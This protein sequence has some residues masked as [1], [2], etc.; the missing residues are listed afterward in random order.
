MRRPAPPTSASST[1]A[2]T[3]SA[4]RSASRAGRTSC[5]SSTL[6]E[7][8]P[9]TAGGNIVQFRVPTQLERAGDFSQSR[10][11]NGNLINAIY[12]APP[13]CR[14][15]SAS[16]AAPRRPA[17]RTAESSARSRRTGCTGSGRTFSTSGRSRRTSRRPLAGATTTRP[18]RR[19]ST[20]SRRSPHSGWTIRPRRNCGSAARASSRSATPRSSRDRFRASTTRG[21]RCRTSTRGR[22]RRTTGSAPT[23]FFEGTYGFSQNQLGAPGVTPYYNKNNLG[24]GSIP[25][26]YPDSGKFD[27]SYYEVGDPEQVRRAILRRRRVPTAADLGLGHQ[28]HGPTLP[29]LGYPSFLNLNR[30]QSVLGSLTKVAGPS[31][32]ES[33][34]QHPAQLQGGE[35]EH[36]PGAVDPG[37]HQFREGHQQPARH[38]LRLRQCGAR[39]LQHLRAAEHPGRRHLPAQHVRGLR[40]GQLEGEQPG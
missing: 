21:T 2:G 33:R 1:T 16:R 6:D 10:D 12:D 11:N 39:H 22:R 15:V 13:G 9:R 30:T 40:P 17:S 24:L 5:S 14:R 18:R 36:R 35:P 26:L 38:R 37:R 25:T 29:N 19:S 34:L 7:Y 8:R 4:V 20:A 32:P 31:H 3:R 27:P 28:H 23:T